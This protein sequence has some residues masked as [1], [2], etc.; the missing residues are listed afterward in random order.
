MLKENQMFCLFFVVISGFR[1]S[2]PISDTPPPPLFLL[3]PLLLLLFF[4]SSIIFFSST[5]LL[6]PSSSFS[7]LSIS[8]F[9]FQFIIMENES[10]I[11]WDGQGSAENTI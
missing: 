6:P 1:K 10:L 11:F 3:L 2:D 9:S 8:P 4:P 7:P 5:S